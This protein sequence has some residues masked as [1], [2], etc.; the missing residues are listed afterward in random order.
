MLCTQG[1]GITD[2]NWNEA[3]LLRWKGNGNT[4]QAHVLSMT[5]FVYEYYSLC[6]AFR[7][8]QYTGFLAC[9]NS[10]TMLNLLIYVYSQ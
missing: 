9:P 5:I 1:T 10:M 4:L 8:Y 3:M 6:M 7:K 2:Y